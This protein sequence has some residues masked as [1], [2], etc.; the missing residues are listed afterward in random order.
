MDLY[1]TV[2]LTCWQGNNVAGLKITDDQG[3]YVG[4]VRLGGKVELESDDNSVVIHEKLPAQVFGDISEVGQVN[5]S[6]GD[7]VKADG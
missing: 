3:N 5:G 1:A 6:G 4:I 7:E 2:F